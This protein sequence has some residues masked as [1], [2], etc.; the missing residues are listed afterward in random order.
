MG[1]DLDL[2]Q[3]RRE[4]VTPRVKVPTKL[5]ARIAVRVA[6]LLL[7]SEEV[8]LH[9]FPLELGLN[10]RSVLLRPRSG[11]RRVIREAARGAVH[12]VTV[13]RH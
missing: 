10:P 11:Q 8:Q 4:H 12:S 2:A 1:G 7:A 3:R 13:R 5:G 9:A 6:L